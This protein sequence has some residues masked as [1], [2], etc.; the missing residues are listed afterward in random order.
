LE[1]PAADLY[2]MKWIMHDWDDESCIAILS[3]IRKA[4]LP[5]AKIMM[6][7]MLIED[8]N[9]QASLMDMNM[10]SVTKGKERNLSEYKALFQKGG[11]HFLKLTRLACPLVCLE[12]TL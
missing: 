4:M 2:L 10:L 3:N 1:V 12:I 9:L 8:G 6:F 11:L 7:E 5:G